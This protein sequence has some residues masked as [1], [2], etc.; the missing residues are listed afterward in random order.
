[1]YCS[2]PELAKRRVGS[3]TGT[4]GEE[5]KKTWSRFFTKYSMKVDRTRLTG[6]AVAAEVEFTPS[7]FSPP[8]ARLAG[9]GGTG[10]CW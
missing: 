7:S 5:G 2:L 9:T 8:L 1:M 3:L 4:T 6:Q 10:R